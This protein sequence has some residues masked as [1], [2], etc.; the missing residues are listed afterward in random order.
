M[1]HQF[2]HVLDK[3]SCLQ[4][5]SPMLL[6]MLPSLNWIY[7]HDWDIFCKP[8][9]PCPFFLKC[10]CIRSSDPGTKLERTSCDCYQCQYMWYFGLPP[11]HS[12]L[13]PEDGPANANPCPTPPPLSVFSTSSVCCTKLAAVAAFFAGGRIVLH[14]DCE[15]CF[16]EGVEVLSSSLNIIMNCVQCTWPNLCRRDANCYTTCDLFLHLLS[17]VM[18]PGRGWGWG[19]RI[20]LHL[21]H[22]K[23]KHTHRISLDHNRCW[24]F[25]ECECLVNNML[26]QIPWVVVSQRCWALFTW[27]N[28][29]QCWGMLWQGG[30]SLQRQTWVALHKFDRLLYL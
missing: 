2:V 3:T 10:F 1:F 24:G 30:R 20:T 25:A 18:Y 4:L 6:A 16:L 11:Y 12:P 15:H 13:F 19:A 21:P 29:K 9:E 22:S 8:E 23:L 5:S 27:H 7:V 28:S 14:L 26:L 17:Q